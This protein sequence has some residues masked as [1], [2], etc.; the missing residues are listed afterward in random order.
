MAGYSASPGLR[1]SLWNL[2][3]FGAVRRERTLLSCLSWFLRLPE[4]RK[5]GVAADQATTAVRPTLSRQIGLFA[6]WSFGIAANPPF[7][8]FRGANGDNWPA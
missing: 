4:N 3:P 2:A 1:P 8:A 6:P 7:V 5:V